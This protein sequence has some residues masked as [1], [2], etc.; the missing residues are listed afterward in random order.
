MQWAKTILEHPVAYAVHRLKHFNSSLLFAVPLKHNRL[1]PEFRNDDPAFPPREVT[2]DREIKLDIL[3]KN[4]FV[5][6]VVW[7]VWAAVVL[8]Y[9]TRQPATPAMALSQVLVVSALGYSGAYLI[10]GVATDLRYHY[11]T[12]IAIM[13]A[14]LIILPD[15]VRGLQRRA[16]PLLWGLALLGTIV[17]IGLATR[18]LDF[19]SLAV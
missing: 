1:A 11:W 18:L 4:P 3:R 8:I 6:P 12:M 7:L 5:W 17:G 16:L 2:S 19:T 10:I 13:S 9:A 15:L 14:S